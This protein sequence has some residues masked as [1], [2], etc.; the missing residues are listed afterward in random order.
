MKTSALLCGLLLAT[1]AFCTETS[2]TI[3]VNKPFEGTLVDSQTV[4]VSSSSTISN[5]SVVTVKTQVSFTIPDE[6]P[7]YTDVANEKLALAADTDGSILVADGKTQTW[8]KTQVVAEDGK[9]VSVAAEGYMKDGKLT[10]DV[11]LNDGETVTVVAPATGDK[12]TAVELVGEGS[13]NGITLAL[14]DT[15]IIPAAGGTGDGATNRQDPAL[16]EKYIAWLNDAAKGGAMAEGADAATMANAFAMNTAGKPSLTITAVDPE[17][18]TITVKGETT[19]SEDADPTAV[20]LGT[21]NGKLYLL[22]AE[23]LTAKPTLTEV[24]VKVADG[25]TITLQLPKGARF[26]KVTVDLVEPA[27]ETL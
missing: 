1:T 7:V 18:G 5:G 4:T 25:D 17:A 12:L 9:A 14:V 10:F 19:L 21:I 8:I 3:T 16:I 13:V 11:K 6:T 24:D 2:T 27:A 22:S 23:S 15:S 20:Q 26:N